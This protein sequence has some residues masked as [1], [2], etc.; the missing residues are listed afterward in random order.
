MEGEGVTYQNSRL[1]KTPFPS[2]L[3]G[4]SEEAF[5]DDLVE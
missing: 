3:E 4:E 5:Q 2:S 1:I